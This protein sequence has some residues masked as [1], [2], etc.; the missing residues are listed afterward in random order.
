SWPRAIAPH[1]LVVLNIAGDKFIREAEELY[2]MLKKE[3]VDVILDDRD[4]T[5]GF[6]FRDAEL[7]GFPLLL[8]VGER[9]MRE[10]KVEV[11]VRRTGERF[12]FSFGEV[13][14]GI[15]GLMGRIP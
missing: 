12:D 10:G 15:K 5:P 2:N 9:K 4:E 1:E 3:G 7:I 6:K 8:V 13:V 14:K 11:Q